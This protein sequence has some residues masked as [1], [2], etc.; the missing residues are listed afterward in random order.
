[1][2]VHGLLEHSD[3]LY[4][5]VWRC[6]ID[7]ICGGV[8]VLLDQLMLNCNLKFWPA[9]QAWFYVLVIKKTEII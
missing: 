4:I 5:R 6:M 1:M 9:E 7:T 3:T 2:E 8:P